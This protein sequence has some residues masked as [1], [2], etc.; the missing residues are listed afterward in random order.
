MFNNLKSSRLLFTF[1]LLTLLFSAFTALALAQGDVL[2]DPPKNYELVQGWYQGRATY[3]YEFGANSPATEDGQQVI[4][5]PIY[6]LVTGFD[7]EGNPQPVEGQYNIVDVI[8]GDE[9]YSDL[10]QVNFVTVPDDY[11]AN[12][13]TSAEQIFNGGY[14]I[15][16]SEVL[17]NCP[18]VPKDSTLAEGG[19]PLVQGWYKGQEVHYFEFGQ[20]TINTAPIYAFITGFDDNGDPVFVEGQH[21]VVDV[22]PGDGGYSTF[23]NVNLVQVPQGYEADSIT[24]VEQILEGGYDITQA[25]LLVNCPILRTE[26]AMMAGESMESMEESDEAMADESMESMEESD[27]AMADE[28]MAASEETPEE[29]P[30]TGGVQPASPL[31]IAFIA[32]G[33]VLAGLGLVLLVALGRKAQ[34]N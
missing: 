23:W 7:A 26:E 5:A 17:V 32:G 29:L 30:A 22:I 2:T 19:A 8:P 27:T 12:T 31:W 9:G 11:E 15:T 1:I 6:V 20:N 25:G 3:Y 4:P 14:D 21:N 10:W 33:A 18:I 28:S 16:E 34:I 13:I 24:S